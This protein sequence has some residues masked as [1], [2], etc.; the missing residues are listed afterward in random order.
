MLLS[1]DEF[2]AIKEEVVDDVLVKLRHLARLEAEL[3]FREYKNYPGSLPQFAERISFA[4]NKVRDDVTKVLEGLEPSD[5]LFQEL[6]PLIAEGLPKKL[7]EVAGDRIA[8]RMPVQYQRNAIAS[9]LACK[10]VYKEGI[11]LVEAQP[12]DVVADRAIRYYR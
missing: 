6:F 4:I 3:L 1:K 10:L 2:M 9:A 7:V 11:H 8:T 12:N 5:P